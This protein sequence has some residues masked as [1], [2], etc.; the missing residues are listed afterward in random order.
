MPLLALLLACA[1]PATEVGVREAFD[2]PPPPG[3]LTLD[4][5]PIDGLPADVQPG[6][7]VTVHGVALDVVDR[8]DMDGGAIL[9]AYIAEDDARRW[10]D[11]G[12][13][14]WRPQR[15]GCSP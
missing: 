12:A 13:V 1:G 2:V 10:L 14:P 4:V 7:V 15:S 9:T 11:A 5:G 3:A 6:S 8:Q